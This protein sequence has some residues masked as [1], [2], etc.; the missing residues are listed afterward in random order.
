MLIGEWKLKDIKLE[1][2][3]REMKIMFKIY[4][5]KEITVISNKYIRKNNKYV[6]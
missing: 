3:E 6:S 1:Q 2:I 5:L 4:N